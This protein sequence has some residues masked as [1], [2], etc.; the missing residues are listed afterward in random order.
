MSSLRSFVV[1]LYSMRKI[2]FLL[3][4]RDFQQRYMGSLLGVVWVFLQPLL[5]VGV[6]YMVFTLGLRVEHVDSQVP[7]SIYLVAGIVAWQFFA[8]LLNS[9][10]NSIKAFSYLVKKIDFRLSV[11]PVVKIVGEVLPHSFLMGFS[12]L[13]AW[14][15]GYSPGLH[16]FQLL[17][18]FIA[19]CFLLL[20]VGWLTSST[21]IFIP[22][23]NNLIQL[24]TRFGFWLTP[25]FWDISR[26][27]EQYQWIIRLNPMVYIVEGYR[28]SLT[29]TNWFWDQPEEG[30]YFWIITVLLCL[31]G[32]YAYKSLRPHFAEVV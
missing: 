15:E 12:L 27:P 10:S 26:V 14:V 28:A 13:V 11:L 29:G 20:G 23:V 22:D 16:T 32:R 6:L 18:Y 1:S 3:A 31:I 2:I 19:M 30:V 25:I 7:F 17:Y 4:K 21:S 9:T 8:G 24:L 5:F